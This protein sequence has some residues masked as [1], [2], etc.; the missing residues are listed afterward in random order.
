MISLSGMDRFILYYT[1]VN[2]LVVCGF[3]RVAPS[4]AFYC[5]KK[6]LENCSCLRN[7]DEG[8]YISSR[9]REILNGINESF[10]LC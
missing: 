1:F 9:V 8:I 7:T 6:H 5:D 2:C 4:S 10:N 3:Q